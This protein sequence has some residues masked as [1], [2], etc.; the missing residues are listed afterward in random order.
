MKKCSK[1]FRINIIL[2]AALLNVGGCA[3]TPSLNDDGNI[4]ESSYYEKTVHYGTTRVDKCSNYK[5]RN[6]CRNNLS[7]FET[8]NV[9]SESSISYGRVKVKI[10]F[11]KKVGGVDGMLLTNLDENNIS[12]ESFI[13]KITSNDLLIF[14][15]GFNTSFIT[16]AIRC[17]QLSHDTNFKGEAVFYSWPSYEG[18][19]PASYPRDKQRAKENFQLFANF[20]QK[21]ANNTDKKIHIVAHSMGTN[22]LMNSLA[23]LD[24]RIQKNDTILKE[25]RNKAKLFSQ[26]IFAAPDIAKSE[27]FV[28]FNK[29]NF[30]KMADGF[31][32]YSTDNDAVLDAAQVA[33]Y[34]IEGTGEIRL[35]ETAGSFSI[36]DGMNTIDAREDI[37]LQLFGHS[38]YANYRSMITDMH[39]LLKYGAHPD[40]RMLQKVVD[41]DDNTLWFIRD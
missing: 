3:T 18:L 15:H 8:G 5:G 6:K 27:F 16:A 26:I 28:N 4:P 36:I 32:L 7:R 13:S 38:Y 34:F 1:I 12:W 2:T 25:R 21:I 22:I 9:R 31:T 24:Q 39:L 40:T 35:G 30:S 11:L 19:T 17:A 20:L 41:K 23:I 37:P 33:N 10:P 14:I 29:H